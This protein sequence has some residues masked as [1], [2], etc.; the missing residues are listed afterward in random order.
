MSSCSPTA[1]R[2]KSYNNYQSELIS[3]VLIYVKYR[4]LT[5]I[6]CC[7]IYIVKS[8]SLTHRHLIHYREYPALLLSY[9]CSLRRSIYTEGCKVNHFWSKC[10]GPCYLLCRNIWWAQLSLLPVEQ[11]E[12]DTLLECTVLFLHYIHLLQLEEGRGSL[13]CDVVC[14]DDMT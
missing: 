5:S 4:L 9:S 10:I 11:E 12:H 3:I 13:Y 14:T 6:G 1:T 7:I 8:Q 2:T